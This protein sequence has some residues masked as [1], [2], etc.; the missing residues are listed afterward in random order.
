MVKLDTIPLRHLN[1]MRYLGLTLC[2]LASL[3][4]VL[5]SC[6]QGESRLPVQGVDFEYVPAGFE[7]NNLLTLVISLD[8][9]QKSK[10]R[11]DGITKGLSDNH[12]DMTRIQAVNGYAYKG[13]YQ[14]R[15]QGLQFLDADKGY[16]YEYTHEVLGRGLRAG[17]L[18][19]YFS[20]YEA[21]KKARDNHDGITLVLEDDAV[22]AANFELKLKSLLAHAPEDWDAIFLHCF[23]ERKDLCNTKDFPIVNDRFVSLHSGIRRCIPGTMAY[24]LN[25]RGAVKVL[26]DMLP[27]RTTTDDRMM[28]QLFTQK[29]GPFRVYCALPQLALPDGSE[30]V[31]DMI[32]ERHGNN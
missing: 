24:I 31:I 16:T 9:D 12:I 8:G 23:S 30:S 7:I 27:A 17:E 21:A 11:L 28:D 22:F 26:H 20:H 15:G 4:L 14:I 6:D 3:F 5:I 10:N 32:Q 13:Q 29:Q 2:L 18:G 25:P 19:N 1:S